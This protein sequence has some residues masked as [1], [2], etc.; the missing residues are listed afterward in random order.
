MWD[1]QVALK[2]E[3]KKS[4]EIV[5][6]RENAPRGLKEDWITFVT[7]SLYYCENNSV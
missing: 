5:Q 3:F 1:M 4:C 6:N 7:F 2:G